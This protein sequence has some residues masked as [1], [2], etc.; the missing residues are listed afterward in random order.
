MSTEGNTGVVMQI[1]CGSCFEIIKQE[2]SVSDPDK[3]CD[4]NYTGCATRCPLCNQPTEVYL[5]KEEQEAS[6]DI[7]DSECP[8]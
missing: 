4:E 3:W 7:D 5:G 2:E 1:V 6:Y 8:F